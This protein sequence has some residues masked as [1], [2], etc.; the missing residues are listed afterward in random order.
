MKTKLF[1]LMLT[2]AMIGLTACTNND[3]P[4]V[5]PTPQE[6]E[7][8]TFNPQKDF[9]YKSA[10]CS[11]PTFV[12]L[13]IKPEVRTALESFLTSITS[14][15]DAMMAIVRA[16]DM[17]TYE[18]KLKELYDRGGFIVVTEPEREQLS[19]FTDKYGIFNAMPTETSHPILLFCFDKENHSIALHVN[20]TIDTDDLETTYKQRIFSFFRSFKKHVESHEAGT[21]GVTQLVTDFDPKVL[22]D[23]CQA[24]S[25]IYTEEVKVKGYD[26]LFWTDWFKTTI[27]NEV[28]YNVYAAYVYEDCNNAGDYYFVVNSVTAYNGDSFV[29]Y[30]KSHGLDISMNVGLYMGQMVEKSELWD[31]HSKQSVTGIYFA[32]D[33]SPESTSESSE[34]TSAMSLELNGSLT[35]GTEGLSGSCGFTGNFSNSVTRKKDDLTIKKYTEDANRS[36]KYVY[37][38]NNIDLDRFS[39]FQLELDNDDYLD[40]ICEGVPNQACSDLDVTGSWCWR[41]PTG[42]NNVGDNKTASFMIVNNFEITYDS[43]CYAVFLSQKRT[44]NFKGYSTSFPIQPPCRVP[45]GIIRLTNGHPETINQVTIWKQGDDPKTAE[46]VIKFTKDILYGKEAKCAVPVGTYYLEYHQVDPSTNKNLALWK[47]ENIEVKNGV[48]EGSATSNSDIGTGSATLIES[49][50]DVVPNE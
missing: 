6:P 44:H 5:D 45:F 26:A 11:I 18:G 4:V 39:G 50:V 43:Y 1:T 24:F 29:P 20:E 15:D 36:V 9:D 17:G 32:K 13:G 23:E 49:Y 8:P 38:I 35:A 33:P 28:N 40:A 34:Y 27:T 30:W 31:T 19:S 37:D 10:E 42:T 2:A 46:P 14:L 47:I 21:R 48:D 25:H 16:E 12:S 41:V 22:I 3:V 7:A